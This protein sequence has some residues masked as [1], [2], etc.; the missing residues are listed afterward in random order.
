MST[1]SCEGDRQ[2]ILDWIAGFLG[3]PEVRGD[4][5]ELGSR[6]D[7]GERWNPSQLFQDRGR[8][9]LYIGL[10]MRPGPGVHVVSNANRLPYD[11]CSFGVVICAEMLEHDLF[12]WETLRE[13]YRVLH[14][15]GSLVI[16]T[17]GIGFPRH[18]FPSD[19]YRFTP[20][21]LRGLLEGAGFERIQVG[22]HKPSAGVFASGRKGRP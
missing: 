5:L 8:F 15:G 4:T 13:A 11:A 9:P 6:W 7:A 3:D 10:D 18:D 22:E 19:Y 1:G 16:T 20:D 12:F 21:A 14:E 17:R 2:P